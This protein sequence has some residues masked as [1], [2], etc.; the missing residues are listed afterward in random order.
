VILPYDALAFA[1]D[2]AG[3]VP[4]TTAE[5]YL[6]HC[7]RYRLREI[8]PAGAPFIGLGVGD[9]PMQGM[10]H[11]LTGVAFPT[12]TNTALPDVPAYVTRN[13]TDMLWTMGTGESTSLAAQGVYVNIYRDH[14]SQA[15]PFAGEPAEGVQ[16][17]RGG[18]A[19]P[20]DDYYFTDTSPSMRTMVAPTSQ[21]TTGPNGTGLVLRQPSLAPYTGTMGPLPGGCGW[22]SS[23]G[24]TI[25]PV[26]F[27]QIH[28]PATPGCTF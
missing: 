1:A 26:V 3:A 17:L 4:L 8:E 25:D 7:G 21:T 20:N 12:A 19:I 5:T 18:A 2:P 28:E 15:D 9:H 10:N 23:T 27:V 11:K 24:A 14:R 22:Y 13:A 6:D 16:I